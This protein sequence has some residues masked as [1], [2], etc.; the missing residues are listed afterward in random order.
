MYLS[1]YIA[2]KLFSQI[3]YNKILTVCPTVKLFFTKTLFFHMLMCLCGLCTYGYVCS[4]EGRTCMWVYVCVMTW[5]WCSVSSLIALHTR[6]VADRVSHWTQSL[7][8]WLVWLVCPSKD[9]L[10][11]SPTSWNYSQG[12]GSSVSLIEAS[13]IWEEKNLNW[14][15]PLI[16]QTGLQ[17]SLEEVF[18]IQEY[19]GKAQLTVGSA[20]LGQEVVLACIKKQADRAMKRKPG[21]CISPWLRLQFLPP[22][23]WPLQFLS[24]F[25][26]VLDWLGHKPFLPQVRSF[27][28][29]VGSPLGQGGSC[30]HL[31]FLGG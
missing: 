13:V 10:L 5:Y 26:L 27:P 3:L 6:R 14:E 31:S 15:G 22:G 16:N 29:S 30:I 8:F 19:C 4:C 2:F 18:C 23:I 25:P 24:W 17:T 12:L 11:P 21:S 20:S 9:S 7:P 28:I 1:C